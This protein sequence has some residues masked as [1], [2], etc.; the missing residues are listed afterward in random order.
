LG[1]TRRPCSRQATQGAA[2]GIFFSILSFNGIWAFILLYILSEAGLSDSKI[3]IVFLAIAVVGLGFHV[4]LVK[5]WPPLGQK[6]VTD[7]SVKDDSGKDG[8]TEPLA[9]RDT[10]SA[11]SGDAE[12]VEGSLL[13]ASLRL[14][15]ER[16]MILQAPMALWAGNIEGLYWGAVAEPMN[17]SLL[18]VRCLRCGFI[19]ILRFARLLFW[20][21]LAPR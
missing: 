1:S 17:T 7:D 6:D 10:E 12:V 2:H 5:P 8:S 3:M 15:K 4:F 18:S 20:R 16:Q 21:G 19:F 11:A 14:M 9:P 13:M